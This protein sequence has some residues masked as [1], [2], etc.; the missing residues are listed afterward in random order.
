LDIFKF[1]TGYVAFQVTHFFSVV[2][3]P[4]EAKHRS[5]RTVR[6][7]RFLKSFLGEGDL[8]RLEW[9]QAKNTPQCALH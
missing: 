2:F 7:E 6:T 8:Y 4:L 3:S 9:G 1:I 5:G